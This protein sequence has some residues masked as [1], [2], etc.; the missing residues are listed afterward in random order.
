VEVLCRDGIIERAARESDRKSLA[1]WQLGLPKRRQGIRFVE[2]RCVP[3]WFGRGHFGQH[4]SSYETR[5]ITAGSR[6]DSGVASFFPDSL[7][8][9]LSEAP[10]HSL[11]PKSGRI[12]PSPGFGITRG[13]H[14]QGGFEKRARSDWR[15]LNL[16]ADSSPLPLPVCRRNKAARLSKAV[17]VLVPPGPSDP[18]CG[19][20]G[21]SG[22][23]NRC[24]G[25]RG[26]LYCSR[27]GEGGP[28]PGAKP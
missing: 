21:N 10:P 11:L 5:L 14:I 27:R 20:F 7:Q 13:F 19:V 12:D 15:T 4:R 8:R 18:N 2:L 24:A 28:L 6:E 9:S 3:R 25:T 23:K 22:R 16:P 26:R 17:L 1:R